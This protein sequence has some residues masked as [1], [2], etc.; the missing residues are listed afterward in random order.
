MPIKKPVVL[1]APGLGLILI[2]GLMLLALTGFR[3]P[4]SGAEIKVATNPP[5]VRAQ[6]SLV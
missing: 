5:A 1:I 6:P 2:G 4:P 3:L